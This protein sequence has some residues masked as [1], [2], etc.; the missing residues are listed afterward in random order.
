MSE[1]VEYSGFCDT[2]EGS[3]GRWKGHPYVTSEEVEFSGFCAAVE[4]SRGW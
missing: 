4:D 1:E 2:V 3:R